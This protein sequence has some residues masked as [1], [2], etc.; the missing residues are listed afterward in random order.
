MK[1]NLE[2]LLS[3]SD[4]LV[5]QSEISLVQRI[6]VGTSESSVSIVNVVE[7]SHNSK[8]LSDDLV[9][10][11]VELRARHERKM[12]STMRIHCAEDRQQIPHP[13][14]CHVR[15]KQNW[16]CSNRHS[17]R[18][19]MLKR[20]AVESSNSNWCV[21]L[22]VHLV[23]HLVKTSLSIGSL[24]MKQSVHIVEE[25]LN[26]DDIS[27]Q[28]QNH[29]RECRECTQRYCNSPPLKH[30]IHQNKHWKC[31]QLIENHNFRCVHNF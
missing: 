4:S 18:Q 1:P 29:L 16:S 17:I 22:M 21:P 14:N 9:V 12:I 26:H 5:S 15:S 10:V 3:S 19:E 24:P 7:N 28:M 31:R 8:V 30:W 20:M 13:K 25:N 2:I 23:N 6:V 11:V 27:K